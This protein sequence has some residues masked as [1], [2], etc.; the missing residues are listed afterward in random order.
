MLRLTFEEDLSL[1]DLLILIIARCIRWFVMGAMLA[2]GALLVTGAFFQ[3]EMPSKVNTTNVTPA[4]PTPTGNIPVAQC[5]ECYYREPTQEELEFAE[6]VWQ[7][8]W[9]EMQLQEMVDGVVLEK[10]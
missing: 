7:Q 8:A 1:R 2:L 9:G 10:E 3:D 4:L 5:P 6:R